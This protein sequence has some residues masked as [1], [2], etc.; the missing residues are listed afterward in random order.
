MENKIT[1]KQALENILQTLKD[2]RRN[3][4][5]FLVEETNTNK[6]S[7][8][9]EQALTNYET[10]LSE[11][12]ELENQYGKSSER[13]LELMKKETKQELIL[14][15]LKNKKVDIWIVDLS[16]NVKEYNNSAIYE[17]LTKIEFDLIKEWLE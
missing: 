8:V 4:L 7:K 11:Y 6:Y 15:V 16:K 13:N 3:P 14:L 2:V 5:A 10:L 9:I 12:R 1:P 17:K